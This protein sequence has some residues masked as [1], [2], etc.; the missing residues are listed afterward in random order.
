MPIVVGFQ[1]IFVD[2]SCTLLQ[3]G[4]GSFIMAGKE[5][6]FHFLFPVNKEGIIHG[7]G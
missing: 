4:I 2:K 7:S 3:F 5:Q 1:Q 6:L